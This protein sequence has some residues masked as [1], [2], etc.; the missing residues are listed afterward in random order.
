MWEMIYDST[1]T[2]TMNC[3]LQHSFDLQ[4]FMSSDS[5]HLTASALAQV[6]PSMTRLM[7][8]IASFEWCKMPFL[9][10]LLNAFLKVRAKSFKADSA[11]SGAFRCSA[12]LEGTP[13][14]CTTSTFNFVGAEG[15]FFNKVDPSGVV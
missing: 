8:W 11:I 2:I 15:P 5:Y 12:C 3:N 1:T 13:L 4:K 14:T 10:L 7:L 6:C 9:L